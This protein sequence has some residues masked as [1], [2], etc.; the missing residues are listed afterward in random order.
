MR[1][2]STHCSRPC[3][4]WESPLGCTF[5][6]GGRMSSVSF[7]TTQDSPVLLSPGDAPFPQLKPKPS[8]NSSSPVPNA[9]AALQAQ[10]PNTPQ[11]SCFSPPLYLHS[12]PATAPAWPSYASLP[13]WS[14]LSSPQPQ[15]GL[16]SKDFSFYL[17]WPSSPCSIQALPAPSV[18]GV[19]LCLSNR[20]RSFCLRAFAHVVPSARNTLPLPFL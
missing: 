8:L 11:S 9:G 19:F 16:F 17:V 3:G 13:T 12:S 5:G 4:V 15:T 2:H 10:P 1:G 20:P 14:S 7:L 6:R 18:T